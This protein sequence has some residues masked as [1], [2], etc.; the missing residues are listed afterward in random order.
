M[1]ILLQNSHLC[2][3]HSKKEM[4]KPSKVND[5]LLSLFL[6]GINTS[7]PLAGRFTRVMHALRNVVAIVEEIETI[8]ASLARGPHGVLEDPPTTGDLSILMQGL[9]GP[10]SSMPANSPSLITVPTSPMALDTQPA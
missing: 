4:N 6:A 10:P 5:D 8:E 3:L 9:M 1:P 2:Y 7:M